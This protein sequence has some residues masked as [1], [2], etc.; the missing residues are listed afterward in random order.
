MLIV[1]WTGSSPGS[2]K[3]RFCT[4]KRTFGEDG[5]ALRRRL[6][7][8]D[9]ELF[10]AVPGHDVHRTRLPPQQLADL[11]QHGIAGDVAAGVVDGLEAVDVGEEDRQREIVAPRAVELLGERL[12][13]PAA[14]RETGER[15]GGGELLEPLLV[16][17][18]ALEIVRLFESAVSDKQR[19]EKLA[20]TD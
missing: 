18:R 7:H 2:A 5:C 10:A 13:Q 17:D 3:S 6:R 11:S 16:R 8:H 14:V 12:R 15:V 1:T 9:D 4:R 20:A 19:L